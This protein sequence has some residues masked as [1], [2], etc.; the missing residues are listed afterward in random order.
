MACSPRAG[1]VQLGEHALD[2]R[3]QIGVDLVHQPDPQRRRCVEALTRDEVAARPARPD[4]RERE[5][6]DH[7]RDD[8]ELHLREREHGPFVRDRDVGAGDEA[9]PAAERVALNARDDRSRAAVDRLQHPAKGV[10]VGHVCV[11]VE[12]DRGAHPLDVRAGAEARPVAGEQNRSRLADVDERLGE[13][14]DQ[15][16]VEGVPRLG[17]RERDPQDVVVAFD[18]ECPHRAEILTEPPDS[19]TAFV[20]A[21]NTSLLPSAGHCHR[22]F[23]M[24]GKAA[25]LALVAL[26]AAAVGG[27]SPAESA[28]PGANGRLVFQRGAPY[29]GGQSSLFLVN[30]NGTGLVQ[31]TR[32]Y[33]HDAQPSWSPDGSQI[34]FES[35]RHSDTDVY[36]I[37]PD[38]SSLKEL[39]FSRGFDGDP[40]WN[41]D[42]TRIAFETSRN[43][44]LD[45]YS[46]N[47]DG[48]G[49]TRLTTSAADD[50]DPAWSPDG[51]RIA[52]MSDRSGRRQVWVMNAD[53]TGQTQLTNAANIGG[54]NPSWS[55]NGRTIV[56]DS[57]R[58]AAG[59]LDIWSMNADGT[60]QRRLTNSPALDALP[61]FS[62][63]GRSIVFVSDRT[64]KDNREFFQMT[65]NGGSQH[66]LLASRL[67]DMSPDWGPSLGRAGC[68]ITGTIN[69]DLLVGTPGRDV[70]CGLGGRDVIS[71]LGGNDRLLGEAG[72]DSIHGG[73]GADLVDGGTGNDQL[74]GS[75]GRDTIRGGAGRRLRRRARRR[76]GHARRW[77]GLRPRSRRSQ[78]RHVRGHREEEVAPGRGGASSA[79]P[80]LTR[81]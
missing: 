15:R 35:T 64:A 17:A 59:N 81:K 36:V 75:A 49:E 47:S 70:I 21:P 51:T 25:A 26:A 42:G 10:R 57:D 9:R 71:G 45:I 77:P 16:G 28:F 72:D 76:A 60:D 62:P 31:L 11:E 78:A 7:R 79:E 12:V 53:G 48:T 24:I 41:D 65:A 1:A 30:A 74:V 39:T 34:A 18:P 40:A 73:A 61:S 50:A 37:R 29:D 22:R 13:L 27:A 33:Q 38:G 46:I 68:T 66:R 5:R 80:R 63:D 44:K 43:G 52:F 54:E 19:L 58:D 3:V 2:G 23:R 6:R 32:G 56:F 55:P 14:G 4:L 69:P 20:V 67:W 8:A